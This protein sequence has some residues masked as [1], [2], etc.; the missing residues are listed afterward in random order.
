MTLALNRYIYMKL[1]N[2]DG[3][4]FHDIVTCCSFIKA[5]PKIDIIAK[6]KTNTISLLHNRNGNILNEIIT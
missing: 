4:V 5:N 1:N 6:S 3:A 2:T